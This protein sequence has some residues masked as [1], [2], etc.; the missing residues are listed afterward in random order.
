M[1]HGNLEMTPWAERLIPDWERPALAQRIP[2]GYS[3]DVSAELPRTLNVWLRRGGEL[4][5]EVHGPWPTAVDAALDAIPQT[6]TTSGG[7]V[8]SWEQTDAD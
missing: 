8:T 1:T 7:W 3:M 6:V 4:V 5:A 2:V